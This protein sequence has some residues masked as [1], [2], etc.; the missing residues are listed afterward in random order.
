MDNGNISEE[1]EELE[2]KELREAIERSVDT[3]KIRDKIQ[4]QQAVMMKPNKI[5]T[6][7]KRNPVVQQ[8]FP[9][10]TVQKK[11]NSKVEKLTLSN[12]ADML[13]SETVVVSNKHKSHENGQNGKKNKLSQ[14]SDTEDE[15]QQLQ[16]LKKKQKP[17]KTLLE[18]FTVV[19]TTCVLTKLDPEWPQKISTNIESRETSPATRRALQED[20]D[21]ISSIDG[22][23]GFLIGLVGSF[24]ISKEE[25][26]DT[27]YRNLRK[28][29]GVDLSKKQHSSDGTIDDLVGMEA[30]ELKNNQLVCWMSKSKVIGGHVW[31]MTFSFAGKPDWSIIVEDQWYKFIC[32]WIVVAQMNGFIQTSAAEEIAEYANIDEDRRIQKASMYANKN[33]GKTITDAFET[34]KAAFKY[35]KKM[36]FGTQY[37]DKL[38][39]G[40]SK[41]WF[42]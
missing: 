18:K 8:Q 15:E 30:K 5:I 33:N 26:G 28:L 35:F 12:D 37:H 19:F 3:K 10:N 42:H 25:S 16:I 11:P 39:E 40:V 14:G 41:E 24:V 38:T 22:D 23:R 9:K 2:L 27:R 32:A 21:A 29:L 31:S 17:E 6:N 4:K 36:L 13:E 7:N 20:I 34:V 1:E